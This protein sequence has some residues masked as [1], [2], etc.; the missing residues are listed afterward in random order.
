LRA[1]LPNKRKL[2]I[3]EDKR[4]SVF[5]ASAVVL[6]HYHNGAAA[7]LDDLRNAA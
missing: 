4:L 5:G 7:L 3:G 6:T 2:W 1:H